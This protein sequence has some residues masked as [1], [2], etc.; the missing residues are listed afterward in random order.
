MLIKERMKKWGKKQRSKQANKQY[1]ILTIMIM[2]YD[3][4]LQAHLT[5]FSSSAIL[6]PTWK[7]KTVMSYT[8]HTQP[9]D[10]VCLRAVA[11]CSRNSS[12]SEFCFWTL[13]VSCLG[14]RNGRAKAI[15]KHIQEGNLVSLSRRT[16]E[17]QNNCKMKAKMS[18]SLDSCDLWSKWI[19]SSCINISW[20]FDGDIVYIHTYYI[21]I[22]YHICI[23]IK[24]YAISDYIISY[25]IVSYSIISYVM[26]SVYIRLLYYILLSFTVYHIILVSDYILSDCIIYMYVVYYIYIYCILF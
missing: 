2:I 22:L 11:S 14:W 3:Y 9:G 17:F 15:F 19:A 5:C 24:Q 18:G 21:Y 16:G 10:A 4:L 23:T 25:H 13:A 1:I 20:A 12:I 8:Q 26:R 7:P 6:Q